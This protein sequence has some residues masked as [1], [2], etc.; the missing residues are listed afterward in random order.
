MEGIVVEDQF[1]LRNRKGN[2]GCHWNVQIDRRKVHQAKQRNKSL[3]HRLWKGFWKGEL[4]KDAWN[5]GGKKKEKMFEKCDV[6]VK[7][8]ELMTEWAE[9]LDTNFDKGRKN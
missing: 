5:I 1:E 3:F 7:V 4:G 6:E 8:N 9:V 2:P